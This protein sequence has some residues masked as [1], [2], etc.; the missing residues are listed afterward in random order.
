MTIND[1]AYIARFFW[2]NIICRHDCFDILVNDK[3]PENIKTVKLL[4]TKYEIKQTV[5]SA[6]HFQANGMVERGYQTIVNNFSKI[7]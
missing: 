2:E 3:K 4:A 6:Y 1:S 5:I 7:R